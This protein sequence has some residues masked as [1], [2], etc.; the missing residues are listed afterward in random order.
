MST[1]VMNPGT[2][3]ADGR[4]GREGADESWA[5]IIAG[6][7]NAA[8]HTAA[9][10]TMR[11][12]SSGTSNQ[13]AALRRGVFL[14][15]PAPLPDG[16]IIQSGTLALYCT[17]KADTFLSSMVLTNA[18]VTAYTSIVAADYALLGG[19]KVEHGTAR[20]TV[21]SITAPGWV[22]WTLNAQALTTFQ[23]LY[24]SG[25]VFELGVYF[26][27]DFDEVAP[28]WASS[29][30]DDI[31]FYA[32]NGGTSSQWPTLTIVYRVGMGYATVVLTGQLGNSGD[33]VTADMFA[34]EVFT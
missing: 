29:T 18:P 16:A 26:D 8:D 1:I 9:G 22:T 6:G 31:N 33:T 23:S 7:G 2:T 12:Q 24:E 28:T 11:L 10:V 5:T 3:A 25:N 32:R 15:D 19:T 4:T 34:V 27:W 30:T 20:I 21:A 17:A 13:W 14:F